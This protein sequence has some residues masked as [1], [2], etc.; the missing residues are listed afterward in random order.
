MLRLV[1]NANPGGP[2]HVMRLLDTHEVEDNLWLA[3][4]FFDSPLD[5]LDPQQMTSLALMSIAADSA[6]G[7]VEMIRAGVIDYDVK[8]ANIAFK[9]RSGRA[10][11]LDLGCARLFGQKPV[12][13]TPDYVAPEIKRRIPSDTSPCYGWAR[14]M[15]EIV[16][17]KFGLG[18]DNILSDYVPWVG[19][20]FAR[21]VAQCC[22]ED[23]R[24]RP[25]VTELYERVKFEV[26]N[27]K[28]CRHCN[29]VMFR[30]GRCVNCG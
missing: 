5:S 10:A 30:D 15:E 8:P 17:G 14:T 25:S 6:K 24:R 21:L 4:E 3:L 26:L 23:P 28:R 9:K 29:A 22:H 16:T 11:H 7:N 20:E 1:A 27:K 19:R 12:G 13:Y 2:A 18:P